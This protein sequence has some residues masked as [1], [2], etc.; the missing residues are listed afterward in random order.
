MNSKK[1]VIVGGGTSGWLSA[2]Y[3]AKRLKV[4]SPNLLDITL[5]ESDDIGTIGVGEATIPGIRQ[6]LFELG[7][8]E[9]VFMKSCSATFKQAIKF[10][11]W[12]ETPTEES[13]SSYYHNFSEPLK[14]G[15]DTYAQY[16]ALNKDSIKRPY[17]YCATIQGQLCDNTISPKRMTDKDYTGPMH[18]AYHFDAGKFSQLLSSEAKK[19]GVKHL[20]G[21]VTETI[22]AENGAIERLQTDK[23]GDLTADLFIDCTG[24]SAYLIEK[25]MGS[26]FTSIKDTLF[27]DKAVTCQV[28]YTEGDPIATSTVSTAQ[29]AGWIWDIALAHRRGTGYVYSSKYTTK[30]KAEKVL[31]KYIGE[32]GENAQLRHLDMRVGYR[33]KQWVKNCVSIG[34]SAGFIEPLESTGIYLVEIGL[35]T[36][37]NLFPWKGECD[38]NATQFNKLMESQFLGTIDFIKLH[39]ALSNRKDTAFW[40]D[41]T[42]DET[43][44][45][46]LKE[47]LVRCEYRV[48]NVFDLPIG[49]Q[50][51][52]IF[53]YYA[54]L[55]GMNKVP[56]LEHLRT[57]YKY[58]EQAEK[59]PQQVDEILVKATKELP[60]HRKYIE[61]LNRI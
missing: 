24:F 43:F 34:L 2:A 9:K 52:N 60:N 3:L 14:A 36:L 33:S 11:D 7:I 58:H 31:R 39:Y 53:S 28:E 17:A 21:K 40:R 35:K 20:V 5:I 50:C 1:I 51:F 30:E 49:P 56:N 41:N 57:H 19:N 45:K 6:T 10:V 23:H 4:A 48:P 8:D 22:L 55:Y 37:I 26:E 25:K 15:P 18:Y 12:Q 42:N 29:E 61:E 27:V 47:F 46:T 16:W 13:S 38:A 32:K 54:V 44:P 59:L